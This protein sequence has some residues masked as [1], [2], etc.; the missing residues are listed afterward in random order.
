MHYHLISCMYKII[1]W[2]AAAPALQPSLFQFSLELCDLPFFQEECFWMLMLI[3]QD[4]DAYLLR[5]DDAQLP[6]QLPQPLDTF[7]PLTS[8]ISAYCLPLGKASLSFPRR[9]LPLL[10]P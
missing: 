10:L 6:W 9:Q 5:M 8:C 7:C 3:Y 1:A 2:L 4:A